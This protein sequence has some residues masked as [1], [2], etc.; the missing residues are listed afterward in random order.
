MI[1]LEE[2]KI[3]KKKKEHCSNAVIIVDCTLFGW[4]VQS[5]ELWSQKHETIKG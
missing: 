1:E 5:Y 4:N 3:L 2:E